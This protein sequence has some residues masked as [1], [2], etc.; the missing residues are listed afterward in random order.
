MRPLKNNILVVDTGESNKTTAAGIILQTEVDKGSSKPGF[1]LAV[2]PDVQVVEVQDKIA[3]DW[4][5]GLPITIEGEKAI[6]I[7]E[8]YVRGIF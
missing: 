3:L 4:S 1:V 5:K 7:S 8:D 2:G 6:L